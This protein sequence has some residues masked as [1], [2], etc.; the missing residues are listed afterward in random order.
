MILFQVESDLFHQSLLQKDRQGF[1]ELFLEKGFVVHQ[2]L[3]R[4][5]LLELFNKADDTEVFEGVCLHRMLGLDVVTLYFT[6]LLCVFI[7]W[8]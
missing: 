7:Y 1:V 4:Q 5:C 8:Q 2:Y 6:Y 3:G